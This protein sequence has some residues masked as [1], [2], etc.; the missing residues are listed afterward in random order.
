MKYLFI[1]LILLLASCSCKRPT[2]T[3]ECSDGFQID[4]VSNFRVVDNAVLKVWT[5]NNSF[6]VH[7]LVP[8]TTCSAQ[9]QGIVKAQTME[10]IE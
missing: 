5:N 6:S 1:P 9:K 8:G 3:I 7:A 2:Y 4:K 10:I